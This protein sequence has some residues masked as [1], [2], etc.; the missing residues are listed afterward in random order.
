MKFFKMLSLIFFLGFCELTFLQAE[1]IS[2]ITDIGIVN[3]DL[4]EISRGVDLVINSFKALVYGELDGES[5]KDI[6]VDTS[7]SLM[8]TFESGINNQLELPLD[9]MLT[10]LVQT[11]IILVGNKRIDLIPEDF[12]GI[13]IKIK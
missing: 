5:Y 10:I 2:A 13:I 9:D 8:E 11:I 7:K 3:K 4:E 1:E 12:N 6:F